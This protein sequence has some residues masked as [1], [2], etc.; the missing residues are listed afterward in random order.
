MRY[1][2]KVLKSGNLDDDTNIIKNRLR[3]LSVEDV[4]SPNIPHWAWSMTNRLAQKV[5]GISGVNIFFRYYQNYAV[6]YFFQKQKNE[7][8]AVLINH[9]ILRVPEPQAASF[10]VYPSL[11]SR[12]PVLASNQKN[13]ASETFSQQVAR[14]AELFE[15]KDILSGHL[16]HRDALQKL[17][18][19]RVGLADYSRDH[20]R[21]LVMNKAAIQLSAAI[22]DSDFTEDV[23]HCSV[24]TLDFETVGGYNI[25]ERHAL[26][27][28]RGRRYQW[29]NKSKHRAF[30]AFGSNVG[31]R[32]GTIE[33]AAKEMVDQGLTI[34]R[35]SSVYETAPM[36]KTDQPS[37]LNAVCEVSASLSKIDNF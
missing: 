30:I 19:S 25:Y 14:Y 23:E 27:G 34:K 17:W 21:S 36:Y 22:E 24:K 5:L 29:T 1:D 2:L 20:P 15:K 31:D 10:S 28:I 3:Y 9:R 16:Y 4:Q 26:P 35:F 12:L 37:F 6:H 7:P 32:M 18:K 11:A 33:R 8:L 13:P